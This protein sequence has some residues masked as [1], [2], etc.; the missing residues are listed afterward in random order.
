MHKCQLRWVSDTFEGD[1]FAIGF[2]GEVPACGVTKRGM[3]PRAWVAYVFHG[4]GRER[5]AEFRTK[6]EAMEAAERAAEYEASLARASAD[7]ARAL[8]SL[9]SA[10]RS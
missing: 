7:L 5:V 8:L 1:R 6:R 2:R 10:V 4:G 9:P 3:S